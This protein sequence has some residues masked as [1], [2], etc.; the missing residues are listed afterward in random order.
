MTRET[1]E[2]IVSLLERY[3]TGLYR[4]DADALQGV[5][6]RDAHYVSADEETIRHL[7]MDEYL[8]IVRER[9]S[10]ESRGDARRDAID[11]LT[12]GG[13]RLAFARVRCAIAPRYFVDFLTLVEEGGRWQIMSKVFHTDVR[14]DG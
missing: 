10:P 8:P 12:F 7:T 5:F 9:P 6:H 11:S 4:S 14:D 2:A 13:P 1:H 3:F